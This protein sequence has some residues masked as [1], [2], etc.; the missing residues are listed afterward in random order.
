MAKTEK[1]NPDN[2]IQEEK[3]LRD[4]INNGGDK[5]TEKG[6]DEKLPPKTQRKFRTVIT[7]AEFWEP[8]EGEIFE[9]TYME[10]VIRKKDGPK[11]ATEPNQKAGALMGYLFKADN[12]R[13]EIVGNSQQV[14][15]VMSN[16][17]FGD[18]VR[19]TFLGKGETAAKQPFNRFRIEVAE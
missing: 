11:A 17:K 12:G 18:Y 6:Q 10:N 7:G 13:E 9:G 15:E 1:S 3:E 14:M 2:T 4:L 5:P 8:A 16:C 19:F